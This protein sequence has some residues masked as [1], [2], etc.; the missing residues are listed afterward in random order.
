VKF[1]HIQQVGRGEKFRNDH[2]LTVPEIIQLHSH[3]EDEIAH[4]HNIPIHFDIPFAFFSLSK[5][6]KNSL[7]R[8]SVQNILGMLSGGELALCGIGMT[9]PELIYG[10]IEINNLRDVW[11][12]NPGLIHLRE[13][14]PYQFEGVCGQ[15]IHRDICQ[16]SCIANSFHS[17]RK[18]NASYYFC[19]EADALGL[20][21]SSR[22]K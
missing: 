17:T 19:D 11:C 9:V 3:I 20:F 21:P 14:V 1:N 5:L 18:L 4:Q 8:C 12:F 6:L 10:N 13:Q 22:R 7:N 16:G 2:G 15:C